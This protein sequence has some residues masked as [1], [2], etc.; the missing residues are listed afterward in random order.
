MSN[1]TPSDQD[2]TAAP[3]S[4]SA[5]TPPPW[6]ATP[7]AWWTQPPKRSLGKRMLRGLGIMIFILSI[8]IN[9]YLFTFIAVSNGSYFRRQVIRPGNERE[10]IAVYTVSGIIDG[11]AAYDFAKF[12]R[13]TMDKPSVKAVVLRVESPGG[14]VSSSDQIQDGVKKLRE[15]GKKVVVSMGGVAASGGYYIS[16]PADEILAEPT[17]ITGSIGVLANWFIFRGTLDKIGAEPVVMRSTDA[18]AWKDEIS[19]FRDMSDVQRK[20]M[21]SVLDQMQEQ[22]NQVVKNGRGAR[23]KPVQSEVSM[24]FNQ[25]KPDAQTVKYTQIEPLNGKMYLTDDAIKFGLVDAKGYLNEA[26]ERAITLAN[27]T[28]P[29]V[30]DF[31]KR[32]WLYYALFYASGAPDRPLDVKSQ[33]ETL[34]APQIQFLWKVE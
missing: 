8:V 28:K 12:C 18:A 34:Q 29:M 5:A 13:E 6:W 31:S 1:Q 32:G 17:T 2:S 24:T 25:G 9:L 3:R 15:K 10:V 27:V 22:F 11:G 7:P 21:Q 23:L 16:A 14:M 26:I 33:M 4:P 30:V 19:P 20:H